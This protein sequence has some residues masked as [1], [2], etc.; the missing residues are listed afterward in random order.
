[1]F[2]KLPLNIDGIFHIPFQ[3]EFSIRQPLNFPLQYR[4]ISELI[5]V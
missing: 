2:K 5:L 3:P 1:M 4:R